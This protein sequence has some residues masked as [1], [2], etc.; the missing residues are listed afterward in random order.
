MKQEEII[1]LSAEDLQDRLDEAVEKMDK[2][3]LTHKVSPLENPAVIT[4]L[5]KTVARLNTEVSKRKHQ[6]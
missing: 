4:A 1:Q 5:R 3:R 6:A 2:L